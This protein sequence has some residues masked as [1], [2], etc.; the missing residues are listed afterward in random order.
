M[1]MRTKATN[2]SLSN[3]IKACA[4]RLKLPLRKKSMTAVVE[5]LIA[6][7]YNMHFGAAEVNS[8]HV[9]LPKSGSVSEHI[10]AA[11]E[12]RSA[13]V[14]RPKPSRSVGIRSK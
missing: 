11:A 2:L 12:R 7:A 1:P 9:P 4:R 14:K 3:E 5:Q 8:D 10:F 13:A 6:D